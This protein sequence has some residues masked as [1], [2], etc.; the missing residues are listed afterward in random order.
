VLLLFQSSH[1]AKTVVF[2]ILAK[3]TLSRF[4]R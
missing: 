2:A 4:S 3:L 1:S